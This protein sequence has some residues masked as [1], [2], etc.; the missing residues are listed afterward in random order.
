MTSQH[1][2]PGR[3][4]RERPLPTLVRQRAEQTPD[5]LFVT[6]IGVGSYTYGE[7][8]ATARRWAGAL[9]AAGVLP[10]DRVGVAMAGSAAAVIAWL[11]VA[12]SGAVE[13]AVNLEYSAQT[14]L[15]VLIDC[16]TRVL[17]ASSRQLPGL[18]EVLRDPDSPVTTV[19]VPDATGPTRLTAPAGVRYLTEEYI[20]SDTSQKV[21]S[22]IGAATA[23]EIELPPEPRICDTACVIFTSGTTGRSKG[24]AMSWR[25]LYIA[26]VATWD[27]QGLSADDVYYSPAPLFHVSGKSPLYQMAIAGGTVVVRERFS[28]SGYLDDIRK[29]GCTH[30][31]LLL[32]MANYLMAQPGSAEDRNNPLRRV[33]IAPMVA[34]PAAFRDRFGVEVATFYGQTELSLP[35]VTPW[36]ANVPGS[37]G[38]VRPGFQL[39]IVDEH[40]AELPAGS[41]GELVV[42]TDRPWMLLTEYV[43]NPAATAQAWRNGWFHTGDAFRCDAEGNYFFVDRMRDTIRRRGENISSLQVEAAISRHPAVAECAAIPRPSQWGEDDIVLVV[44]APDVPEGAR[45]ALAGELRAM[46]PRYMRPDVIVWSADLPKTATGKVQKAVLRSLPGLV[47][48]GPSRSDPPRADQSHG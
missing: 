8:E 23:G 29:Y 22:A 19:L 30:G 47:A 15:P 5:A 25:K 45:E 24:V 9:V 10:G 46:V 37:C 34:D 4:D 3:D 38:R 40:D 33:S 35:L 11:A 6:D 21:G 18:S 31:M 48:A 13:V 14:L 39:K 26:A 12:K 16:E 27:D 32:A 36:N 17:V 7:I 41:V 2:H 1:P 43:N 20:P 28:A 44:V 42:R